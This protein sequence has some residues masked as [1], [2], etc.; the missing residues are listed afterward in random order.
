MAAH[1]DMHTTRESLRLIEQSGVAKARLSWLDLVLKAFLAGIFISLGGGFTLIVI[2]GAPGLRADNPAL[3]SLVGGLVFPIGFVVII[4]TGME[5]CTLNIFV[6]TY[7]TLQ[8]KTIL[9]DLAINLVVSYVCN[10]CGCLFYAGVLI[11]WADLLRTSDQQSYAS[12]QAEANVN[13][14]WGINLARGIMCNWLIAIAYIFSTEG[15]D[16][17]SKVVGIWIAMATFVSMG[18]QH[19]VVNY[20]MI[21]TGMF[22]GTNFGV[23]KFIWASCIPVTLGNIIG[24]AFFGA[25]M[26]WMI[27][28][29]H[30]LKEREAMREADEQHS[31]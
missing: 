9:C 11:Y 18:F 26:F 4:L 27:Y 3:A 24:G 16:L 2:G 15:R 23:G 6:M 5:L 1:V 7:A 13:V 8:R 20:F 19:S 29:K 22:Y 17:L 10:I 28:G 31:A 30:E 21:P 25:V 12:A 14:G